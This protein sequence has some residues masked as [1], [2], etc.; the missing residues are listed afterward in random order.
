MDEEEFGE[1]MLGSGGP[2]FRMNLPESENFII[3][4]TRTIPTI[5]TFDSALEHHP[6]RDAHLLALL[7]GSVL[8]RDTLLRV[9]EILHEQYI[10]PH[11][12]AIQQHIK[13]TLANNNRKPR[14]RKPPEEA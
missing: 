2:S 10:S 13:A 6:Q 4:G 3:K 14:T 12:E 7:L 1:S 11:Y 8:P 9:A 5:V